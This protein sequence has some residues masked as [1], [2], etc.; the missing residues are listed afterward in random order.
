MNL[1]TRAA[2]RVVRK[3]KQSLL[4]LLL[5]FAIAALVMSGLAVRDAQ[6]EQAEGLRGTVGASFTVERDISTGGWSGGYSTQEFISEDMIRQIAAVDGIEGYDATLIT[7]PDIFNGEGEELAHDDYSF[8]NYGSYNS[9]YHELFLSGRFELVEGTHITDDMSG[10]IIVSREVAERNGLA[11]GDT[12]TGIYY[13]ENDTPAVDMEIV[14]IFDVAADKEDRADMYDD[15]SYYAYSS[16]VF[17]SM[18]AA[19]G[20]IEGWGEE[21]EGI[22]EAYYYVAD[23]AEL[24]S[25]IA[26]VQGIPS[27]DWGN[28]KITAN[29]EVY[30]NVSA[31]LSDTGTLVSAMCAL[32]T[33]VGAVMVTLVLAMSVRGR[34]REAGIMMAA[35]IEKP[36][37]AFQYALES[38]LAAA[39]AFPLAYLA[40]SRFAGALGAVFGK[41][42]EAVVV[43]PEHF[44]LVAAGGTIILVAAIAASFLP[45]ARLSPAQVLSQTD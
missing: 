36:S 2:R 11:L 32:V 10:S 41:S 31:A 37:L 8:Y 40:S 1:G 4:M 23:A 18:D 21:G 35:G 14:G 22:S 25:V 9:Q 44:A 20:L 13:P 42:A 3:R 33:V 5:L 24:D 38:L 19:E 17:C 39:A 34:K 12:V 7:L 43:T 28:F 15:S 30:R 26:R 16:Y 6:G 45:I 27:I 29:D